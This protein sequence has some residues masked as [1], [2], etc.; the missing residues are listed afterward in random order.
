MN[1][2]EALEFIHNTNKFGSKLGLEN[3]KHLLKKLGNPQNE[4]SFIHVA[5]TNGKGSTSAMLHEILMTSGRMV[6]L[7]TS[8]FI[9][10][11][12]ERVRVNGEIISEEE[13]AILTQMVKEAIEEMVAEGH[14]HPTE[15]EVVTA[16]GFLYFKKMACDIVILEVGLGGR[17]DATNV[18][19]ASLISVITPLDFDHMQFLGNTIDKIA[20]EKAGIIKENG[21]T[22]IHPQDELAESVIRETCIRLNNPLT[23]V[24]F[25]KAKWVE[26]SFRGTIFEYEDEQYTLGLIAPYQMHNA[27]VA[28]E[29]IRQLNKHY[30]Y[31]IDLACLKLGLKNTKWAGRMELISE[32]PNVIIDGAHN[33]HGIKGLVDTVNLWKNKYELLALVGIL[34]DKDVAGMLG[35]IKGTF[36]NVIVT[37]PDNYRAM[38]AHA[39][40]QKMDGFNVLSVEADIREAVHKAMTWAMASPETR[41]VLAFGSLYMLGDIKRAV[42]HEKLS[43]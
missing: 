8:P 26:S 28:I 7:Y 19:E 4:L 9:E 15:F 14:N 32:N 37:E 1:Y 5:G 12:E 34:E 41:L 43:L 29:V 33:L 35:E 42:R 21:V 11:F 23:V 10:K 36:T 25:E 2:R 13:L 38:K 31:G 18:I 20:F 24:S 3:I 17:L 39:L 22:V 30:D 40:A 16:I 27:I 6:G